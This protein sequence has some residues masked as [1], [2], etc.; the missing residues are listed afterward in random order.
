MAAG[1]GWLSGVRATAGC[2][3]R[4]WGDKEKEEFE[5]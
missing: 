1:G 2:S 4:I 5:V 3:E